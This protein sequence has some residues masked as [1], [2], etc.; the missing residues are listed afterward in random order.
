M[1]YVVLAIVGFIIVLLF[2]GIQTV[3][4]G[5]EYTIERFG[6]FTRTL[7]PGLNFIT[8]I[9]EKVGA[10]INMME[11]VLDVPEQSVISKDNASVT[12][13][14]VCFYQ[15]VDAPQATYEVNDL[16]RA[17]Q[18]LL[19][20]N[21]RTVLG[22][23]DLDE[24]LSKRD[25]INANLLSIVDE[26]TNPWGIK[27][28]R[29]EIKDILPPRDLVDAMAKQMKAERLKRA[30]ILDAEGEKQS[31]ILVAEGQKESAI[32]QAEGLRQAAFLEAEAR[33]RQAEAESKATEVV[34]AAIA[35]GDIQAINYFVS[36]KY[37]E[38]LTKIG[39]AENS[40]LVLMPL[41]ASSVIGSIAGI[42]ELAKSAGMKTS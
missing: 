2:L 36:Q 29:I 6:K 41:E 37:I 8:P 20:T 28:T 24:M 19:M 38:A 33:E 26:A 10:K 31:A 25:S 15:V 39:T 17:M 9:I 27:V 1:E 12:I 42:A 23:M 22:G 40:K 30:Q 16:E 11:Q 14:A 34:S 35:S 5:H 32:R 7:R 18:N 3:T 13:D 4:Q 21:L